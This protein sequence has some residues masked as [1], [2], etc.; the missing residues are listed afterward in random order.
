MKVSIIDLERIYGIKNEFITYGLGKF[1]KS[2]FDSVKNDDFI[3]PIGGLWSC[4]VN[5]D[6]G[7][8]DWCEYN[9]FKEERLSNWFK[10]KLDE[11]SNVFVID[12][13]EDLNEMNEMANY[14]TLYG[15]VFPDF[16][17][18]SGS[19]DGILLTDIGESCTRFTHPG[20]RGWDVESLLIFNP[21]VI[22]VVEE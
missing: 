11:N 22:E 9:G 8:K 19:F 15:D 1:D 7:W 17:K 20:L 5:S 6:W 21:E 18:L 12:N 10:F 13:P 2:K 3:K 4:P 16:E 14:V